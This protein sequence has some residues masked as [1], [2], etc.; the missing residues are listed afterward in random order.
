[1]HWD[2][3]DTRIIWPKTIPYNSRDHRLD[4]RTLT[5]LFSRLIKIISNNKDAIHQ[6]TEQNEELRKNV[7]TWGKNRRIK[8]HW[9]DH[10]WEKEIKECEEKWK[11][12]GS[13]KWLNRLNYELVSQSDCLNY[14]GFTKTSIIRQASR[15]EWNPEWI[16]HARHF[17]YRY[18]P[19]SAHAMNWGLDSGHLCVKLKQTLEIM[20]LKYA[21]PR[22]I[23]GRHKY[24]QFWSWEKIHQMTP[25]WC[26]RLREMVKDINISP[27]LITADSTYQYCQQP[28]TDQ[29]SRKKTTN[30]HKF[31]SLVKVHIYALLCGTP[32]TAQYYYSDWYHA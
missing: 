1:M 22:L 24:E 15:C 32:L 16:F 5:H 3:N 26:Y 19:R 12:K 31:R 14:T 21:T 23:N 4:N 29:D 11:D 25:S 2:E 6:L 10:D 17:M 13:N 9:P 18:Q 7:T 30:M 20:N 8:C 28:Q 27:I